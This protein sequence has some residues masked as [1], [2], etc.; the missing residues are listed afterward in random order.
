[1]GLSEAIADYQVVGVDS[2]V[3][4]YAYKEHPQFLPIVRPLFERLDADPE[5][6]LVTST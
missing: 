5:F 1:V 2:N 4:I 3:F 6:R